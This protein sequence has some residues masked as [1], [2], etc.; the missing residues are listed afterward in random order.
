MKNHKKRSRLGTEG[1][2]AGVLKAQ[3]ALGYQASAED[4]LRIAAEW[5][6]LEEEA[7]SA[8]EQQRNGK[9]S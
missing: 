9:P 1:K 3:L 6:P 5:F 7:A 2:E 8:D 4:S